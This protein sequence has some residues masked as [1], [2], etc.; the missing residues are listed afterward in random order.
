MRILLDTN[1]LLGIAD[2][3]HVMHQEAVDAVELLDERGHECV[4]VP[5][6]I[7]EYWV[8]AT[9]PLEKKRTRHVR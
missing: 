6:V 8:V 9:R 3:S 2:K 7:Y 4:I 5:Q 1:V